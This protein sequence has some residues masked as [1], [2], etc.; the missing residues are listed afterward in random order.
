MLGMI[1][2]A[3]AK[4]RV[5]DLVHNDFHHNNL[6]RSTAGDLTVIDWEGATAGDCRS[7]LI[8][9]Y[10]IGADADKFSSVARKT[11]ES[12][13]LSM[14]PQ[15]FAYLGARRLL[16]DVAFA[17]GRPAETAWV[18]RTSEAFL[19]LQGRMMR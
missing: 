13:L 6:L 19:R 4:P 14:S 10:L 15:D 7:D 18:L 17:W 1:K 9:L 8:R 3:A 2:T 5:A 12:V 16:E 11:L